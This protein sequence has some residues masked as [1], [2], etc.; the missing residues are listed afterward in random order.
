MYLFKFLAPLDEGCG[1]NDH[2][3]KEVHDVLLLTEKLLMDA[4]TEGVGAHLE[5]RKA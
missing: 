1:G 4:S 5:V 2:Y 3:L